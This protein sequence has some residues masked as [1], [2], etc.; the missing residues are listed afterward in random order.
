VDVIKLRHIVH[1]GTNILKKILGPTRMVVVVAGFAHG[2]IVNYKIT[3]DMESHLSNFVKCWMCKTT[4]VK[5]VTMCLKIVAGYILIMTT[6]VV[7][8]VHRAV[9]VFVDCYAMT[10]IM[11]LVDLKTM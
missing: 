7:D 4:S 9:N 11:G 8:K 2:K 1:R 5:F 6:I 10:V 3:N